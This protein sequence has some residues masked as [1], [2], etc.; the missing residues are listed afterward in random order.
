MHSVFFTCLHFKS[1]G[2]FNSAIHLSV[3]DFSSDSI[4]G[5]DYV[6]CE[7][8]I[9]WCGFQQSFSSS[10]LSI[11]RNS[12]FGSRYFDF[13]RYQYL[14]LYHSVCMLA[15]ANATEQIDMWHL[16]NDWVTGDGCKKM[17]RKKSTYIFKIST[18]LMHFVG[19][20]E[21]PR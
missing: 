21:M 3:I 4:T 11:N 14:H 20:S 15:N 8:A 7:L 18:W 1:S 12:Q 17:L 19:K 13:D 2:I 6:T 9:Q 10:S 5:V 16:I